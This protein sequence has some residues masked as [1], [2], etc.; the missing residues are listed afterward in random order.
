[1]FLHLRLLCEMLDIYIK[2]DFFMN[3]ALNTC[4]NNLDMDL[5]NTQLKALSFCYKKSKIYSKNV[6]PNLFKKFV[7]LG[8]GEA[9]FNQ[10][11]DY[12]KKRMPLIVHINLDKVMN[13]FLK[14]NYLRNLFETDRIG[15]YNNISARKQWEN[16]LFNS[17]Y[18]DVDGHE[19]VKYG[20]LNLTSDPVG[21]CCAIGYGDSYLVFKHDV[22]KRTS[23]VHGDS[24]SQELHIATFRYFCNVLYYLDNKLLENIINVAAGKDYDAKV[25]YNIYVEAQ[26]HGSVRLDRDFEMLVVNNKYKNNTHMIYKLDQLSAKWNLPW[27]FAS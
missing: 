4:N 1:M 8:Y 3:Y 25:K 26:I 2:I 23:F 21:V 20:C 7:D 13:F 19:R 24:S 27:T 16:T 14:D 11:I 5:T 9:E 10:T 18:K 12:I 17:I 6:K 15:G 22:K